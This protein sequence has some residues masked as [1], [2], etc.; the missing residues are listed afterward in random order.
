MRENGLRKDSSQID[1]AHRVLRARVNGCTGYMLFIERVWTLL[2]EVATRAWLAVA[3]GR[4]NDSKVIPT[5]TTIIRACVL[6]C[7]V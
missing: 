7:A 4:G 2:D 6:Q 1:L 3:N 5:S